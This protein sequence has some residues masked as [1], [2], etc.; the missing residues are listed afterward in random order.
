MAVCGHHVEAAVPVPSWVLQAD[1]DVGGVCPLR[2]ESA[3][4]RV[5]ERGRVCAMSARDGDVDDDE[6]QLL[7]R[8][9]AVSWS[10]RRVC[11]VPCRELL[12]RGL[13]CGAVSDAQRLAAGFAYAERLRV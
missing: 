3:Q 2:A 5:H 8:A 7:L 1:A 11:Q 9:R 10:E 12:R 4:D 6:R 13:A